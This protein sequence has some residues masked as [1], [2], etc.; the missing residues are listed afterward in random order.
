MTTTTTLDVAALVTAIESRDVEGQL[1]AFG[2]DPE[3]VVIDH[4]HP[5]NN[6]TVV[7]GTKALREH[8]TDICSRDMAHTVRTAV[9]AEDRLTIELNCQYPD[10]AKVICL[11][12]SEVSDGHITNQRGVQVWD[13]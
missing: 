1:A 12:V 13:H 4:E 10:G 6:P 9:L 11:C 2:S 7:R 3:L 8:L 5:P